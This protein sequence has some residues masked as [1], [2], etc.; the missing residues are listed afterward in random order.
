MIYICLTILLPDEKTI[1]CMFQIAM[2]GDNGFQ[3]IM[4]RKKK[5]GWFIIKNTRDSRV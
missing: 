5:S 4:I 3:H 1:R 2:N